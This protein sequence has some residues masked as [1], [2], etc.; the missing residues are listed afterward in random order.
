MAGR[1]DSHQSCRQLLYSEQLGELYAVS[2]G[3][4]AA[5]SQQQPKRK[6]PRGDTSGLSLHVHIMANQKLFFTPL[7]RNCGM[8]QPPSQTIMKI[9]PMTSSCVGGCLGLLMICA[10]ILQASDL[11]RHDYYDN[12]E[13]L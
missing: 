12:S 3:V 6:A 5:Q 13:A 11:T 2:F 10:G 7:L 4:H 1:A 8:C 9:R